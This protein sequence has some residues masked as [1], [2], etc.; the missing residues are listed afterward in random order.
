MIRLTKLNRE[1]VTVN[2]LYIERIE[3]TPDT[4]LTMV[5][6]RKI[7]VLE[8]EQEVRELITHYYQTINLFAV[9]RQETKEDLFSEWKGGGENDE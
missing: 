1:P 6:G 7:L 3:S 4:V 5:T 8:S 9:I 2:A